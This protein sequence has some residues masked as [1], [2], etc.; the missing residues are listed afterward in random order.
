[1]LSVWPDTVKTG[2]GR[3]R[4]V[5]SRASATLIFNFSAAKS[6]LFA[7]ASWMACSIVMPVVAWPPVDCAFTAA[8]D[9][10]AAINAFPFTD[11]ECGPAHKIALASDG[12]FSRARHHLQNLR[13]VR[14]IPCA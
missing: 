10:I 11:L 4:A 1:M 2:L 9:S 7:I 6:R 13:T 5:I 12:G 14:N 3:S 8:A